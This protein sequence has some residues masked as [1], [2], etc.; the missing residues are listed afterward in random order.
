M[1]S[2]EELVMRT[3]FEVTFKPYLLQPSAMSLSVRVE[4]THP[5]T[6]VYGLIRT[7]GFKTD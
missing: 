6:D 3:G 1:L 4:A 7:K 5:A 2:L